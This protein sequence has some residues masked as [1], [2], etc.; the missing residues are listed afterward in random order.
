M[1]ER[2]FPERWMLA[3]GNPAS[4]YDLFRSLLGPIVS[5]P[6]LDNRELAISDAAKCY[7]RSHPFCR[8]S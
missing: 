6:E 7:R 3:F 2:W 4:D 1:L 5:L 8:D